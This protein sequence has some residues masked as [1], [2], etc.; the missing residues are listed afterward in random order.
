MFCSQCGNTINSGARFCYSCGAA[1]SESRVPAAAAI[2]EPAK[3]PL[4]VSLA[5]L[6]T[7]VVVIIL[8]VIPD[9]KITT[10]CG[11]LLALSSALWA[12]RDAK[13][14]GLREYRTKIPVYSIS[15]LMFWLW[16][17][18]FPWYLVVRSRIKAGV[19][20]KL[21]VPRPLPWAWK[22]RVLISRVVMFAILAGV[23]VF[24]MANKL[25]VQRASPTQRVYDGCVEWAKRTG[26]ASALPVFR[27]QKTNDLANP[28]EALCRCMAEQIGGDRE[29][30]DDAKIEIAL[31]FE[32][33]NRM[34]NQQLALIV[35]SGFLK[36]QTKLV[37][38][39]QKAAAPTPA[40]ASDNP[41]AKTGIEPGT[42]DS[43]LKCVFGVNYFFGA[44]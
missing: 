2:Q 10:A 5:I 4:P 16:A 1:I 41:D 39:Q 14:I 17:V 35:G 37:Q 29:I 15:A 9:E 40:P 25:E 33:K 12:E 6:F 8:V 26:S 18:A 31:Q 28:G 7:V 38:E 13:R 24:F 21:A 20:P 3:K 23:A 34:D 44:R 30:T 32:T 19:T 43:L 27:D 11:L 42:R 22:A 36:C